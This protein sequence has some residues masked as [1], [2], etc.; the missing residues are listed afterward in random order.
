MTDEKIK[1]DGGN[2]EAGLIAENHGI[3]VVRM[4]KKLKKVTE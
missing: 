3:D 2:N 1:A 4:F